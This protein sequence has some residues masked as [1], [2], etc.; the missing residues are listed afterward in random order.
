M[1]KILSIILTV[2]LVGVLIFFISQFLGGGE[3]SDDGSGN[4]GNGN[5]VS[6]SSGSGNS[7]LIEIK[8]S[9]K[10]YIYD[11]KEISL[12]EFVEKVKTQ[13]ENTSVVIE[14]GDA[15]KNAMDELKKCLD[16]N[17]INYSMK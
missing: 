3:D 8:V 13:G 11:D 15:T 16:D 7:S 2:L 9:G 1:K 6:D 10:S 14:D 4:G 5:S 12:D 17:S